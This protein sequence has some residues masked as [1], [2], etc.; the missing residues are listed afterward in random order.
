MRTVHLGFRASRYA[1]LAALAACA[2]GA[3]RVRAAGA[4]GAVPDSVST[5]YGRGPRSSSTAAVGSVDESAIDAQHVGRVE[6]LFQGRL[7]GV[8]V[9]RTA[10]GG[11]SIR[12]R[13]ATTLMADGSSEPLIVV[14]GVPTQS[15][16][17]SV[18]DALSPRDIARIE[19]LKDADATAAFGVR[20]GNGVILIT[21][22]H[23]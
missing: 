1:S 19:V 8:E 11:Y 13:S 3:P 15:G 4:D 14:D 2:T 21:T 10:S 6:E 16:A 22:K 12:I 5:G 7:A 9:R 23:P 20:G 17:G 18:L